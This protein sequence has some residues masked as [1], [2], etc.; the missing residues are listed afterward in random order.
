MTLVVLEQ[1]EREFIK[2]A[3]YYESKEAGLGMRFRDEV[4]ATVNW[5]LSYPEVPRMR[6]V[7][8]VGLIFVCFHITS[9]T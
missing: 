9:L 2:S 5:I 8:T 3:G 1:A 4:V 7:V 6:P